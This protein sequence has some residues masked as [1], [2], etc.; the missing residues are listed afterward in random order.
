MLPAT[1]NRVTCRRQS[2]WIAVALA[3]TAMS[4]ASAQNVIASSNTISGVIRVF[5]RS[6]D[7]QADRSDVVVFVDGLPESLR[8]QDLPKPSQVSHKNRRFSPRVLPVVRGTSVDFLNDDNIFHNVFS[9]SRPNS[10]D[11]GIYPEGTSKLVTFSETGLVKLHCNIHPKMT[12][13]IL[14]LDNDLFAT[15]G[16]DGTFQIDGIPDGRVT[17]RVWSEFSEEQSRTIYIRRWRPAGRIVRR[18]RDQAFR[19]AQK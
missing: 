8:D 16:V 10:F 6:G 5:D 9:L 12:S 3:A 4:V 17:L 13:T 11:L 1:A 7:E 15:T 14:V 19:S 2:I 18:A